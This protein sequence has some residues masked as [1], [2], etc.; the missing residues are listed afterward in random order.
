M[1]VSVMASMVD[2][3]REGCLSAA[4]QMLSFL[5]SKYNTVAVFD[6]AEPSIDYNQFPTED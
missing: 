3:P 1:Q 2:L 4:F 5:K 6:P